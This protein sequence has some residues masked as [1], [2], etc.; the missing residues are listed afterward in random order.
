MT[1]RPVHPIDRNVVFA[2]RALP[3]QLEAGEN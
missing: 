1:Y 3:V 2:S